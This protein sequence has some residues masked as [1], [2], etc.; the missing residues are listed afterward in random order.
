MND[1]GYDTQKVIKVFQDEERIGK[2]IKGLE[3]HVVLERE[4]AELQ[5]L[6][7]NPYKAIIAIKKIL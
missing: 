1:G 7:T 2:I 6:I 4:T 3:K 5:M